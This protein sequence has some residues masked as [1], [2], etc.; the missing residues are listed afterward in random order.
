MPQDSTQKPGPGAH[1][2]EKVGLH[3]PAIKHG[4]YDRILKAASEVIRGLAF[5]VNYTTGQGQVAIACE[6]HSGQ[7]QK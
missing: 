6:L 1:S 2:P 7:T 5:V 4:K 3:K